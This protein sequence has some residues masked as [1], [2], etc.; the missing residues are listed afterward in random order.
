LKPEQMSSNELINLVY[1]L[2]VELE[3]LKEKRKIEA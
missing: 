3:E 1:E 2:E